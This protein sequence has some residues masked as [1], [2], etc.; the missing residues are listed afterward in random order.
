ERAA[1]RAL[2]THFSRSVPQTHHA[3]SRKSS[4]MVLVSIERAPSRG[5]R[6]HL[7]ARDVGARF[8]QR[9]VN[10]GPPFQGLSTRE[11]RERGMHPRGAGK[12]TSR[13]TGSHLHRRQRRGHMRVG[14]HLLASR[15]IVSVLAALLGVVFAPVSVSAHA[16]NNNPNVIH[17]C[18]NNVSMLIRD[19]GAVGACL[20][21]ER[22]EHWAIVGPAGPQGP[23]GPAG[24]Q[25]P[26]GN[27]GPPG[28][29]GPQG[30]IGP[31]GDTGLSGPT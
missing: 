15:A 31:K 7:R 24:P 10:R 16:G 2:P 22:A 6:A 23:V 11:A 5:A 27:A 25:G 3:R 14:K 4:G 12:C 13:S 29:P 20:T 18:V 26:Q 17:A 28:L 21:P 1:P 9:S 8:R 30:P 19:V